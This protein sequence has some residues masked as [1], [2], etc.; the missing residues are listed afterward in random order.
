MVRIGARAAALQ[1]LLQDAGFEPAAAIP[2]VGNA[3]DDKTMRTPALA[4]YRAL[5]GVQ[6]APRLTPGPWDLSFEGLV[7]ELDEE[8]HFNRYRRRTLDEP[9][10]TALPW[11]TDYMRFCDSHETLCLKAGR[12]PSGRWTSPS[13]ERQFGVSAL[14]GE[15]GETGSARW[16]QRA[17]YDAIKDLAAAQGRYRLARLSIHDQIGNVSFEHAL[18]GVSRFCRDE[19]RGF[20]LSRTSV[21]IGRSD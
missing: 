17:L 18:R 2:R 1:V 15:L 3:M 21:E 9:W 14:K 11:A 7:I 5:G 4:M 10:A 6:T 20:V 13:T 16:K 12:N 19:L 8:L